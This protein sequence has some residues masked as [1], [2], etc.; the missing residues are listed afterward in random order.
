MVKITIELQ[1]P[2]CLTV[3][4]LIMGAKLFLWRV[5]QFCT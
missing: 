2:S 3:G 5:C 4:A 1:L